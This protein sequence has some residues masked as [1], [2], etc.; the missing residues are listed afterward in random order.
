MN[1]LEKQASPP[2]RRERPSKPPAPNRS[3]REPTPTD[4]ELLLVSFRNGEAVNRHPALQPWLERDWRVRSAVPRI[5]ENGTTKLLV[6]LERP[7]AKVERSHP[8]ATP[9]S[10]RSLRE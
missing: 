4:I 7:V 8:S 6:V 2:R 10:I 3:K 9:R 5:V 1:I